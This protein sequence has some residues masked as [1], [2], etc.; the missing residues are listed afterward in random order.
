MKIEINMNDYVTVRLSKAGADRLN[1]LAADAIAL[2][3]PARTLAARREGEEITGQLWCLM[4]DFE[5]MFKMGVEAPFQGS[6]FTYEVKTS[7]V[8]DE[9]D[10]DCDCTAMDC[11]GPLA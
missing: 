4:G 8:L 11:E 10:N 5:G 6:S 9:N 3:Y 1:E 7:F 2:G